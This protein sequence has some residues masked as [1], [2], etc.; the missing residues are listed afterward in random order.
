MSE[1]RIAVTAFRLSARWPRACRSSRACAPSLGDLTG[2]GSATGA[3][4]I[5]LTNRPRIIGLAYD[6]LEPASYD[7]QLLD[8]SY[9]VPYPAQGRQ[10]CWRDC[11]TSTRASGWM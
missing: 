6:P 5:D 3:G 2:G 1:L 11:A 9:L 7:R 4:R 10:R 8:A